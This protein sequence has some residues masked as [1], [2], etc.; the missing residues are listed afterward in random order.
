MEYAV[1]VF[2]NPCAEVLN[3]EANEEIAFVKIISLT[4]SKTVFAVNQV[5]AQIYVASL[6]KGIY[7]MQIIFADGSVKT[8]QFIKK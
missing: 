7:N 2:P 5:T 1:S 8:T 3:I 6:S 4:G